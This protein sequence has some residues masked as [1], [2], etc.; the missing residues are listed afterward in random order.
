[1]C[2]PSGIVDTVHPAGCASRGEGWGRFVAHRSEA[3]RECVQVRH[4]RSMASIRQNNGPIRVPDTANLGVLARILVGACLFAA[5]IALARSE[6]PA[7][8]LVE[9]GAIAG[10]AML[11][12][13]LALT[14]LAA[15]A[16]WLQRVSYPVGV[17]LVLALSLLFVAGTHQV[18]RAI[19]PQ[20]P[21]DLL[22]AWLF[23]TIF[24]VLM[25]GY[26]D[27]R[28]RAL[29]PALA[30]ARLQ[31]LQARIRPHFLF[32]SIN[33]VLSLIRSE[34]KRA[35][36][37]LEDMADLFRVLMADNRELTTL[38]REVELC[39]QYLG[40]EQLR[41]GE[42]LKL[43]WHVEKMPADALVPPL[44]LQP[45]LENAVYHGIEPRSE[46]GIVSINIFRKGQQVH[47]VLRNPYKLEGNHHAGNK[48]ALNNI[49]ERLQLH[50]DAEASLRTSVD[51]QAYQ[52]HIVMPFRSARP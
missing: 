18:E 48:M 13:L 10:A 8:F 50:F 38:G 26:F 25:I 52:V 39:R 28:A 37:A 4:D 3:A 19:A 6:T 36:T 31:A 20:A 33:A 11:P 41:L 9:V 40:L 17:L 34:P 42:R 21:G 22:R 2:N 27:L 44:V 12:L 30:E 49:R 32:N 51:S 35:E 29:S 5:V 15:L 16:R 47:A 23:T 14:A 45:L 43:E 24:V 46:P 1:M 7:D